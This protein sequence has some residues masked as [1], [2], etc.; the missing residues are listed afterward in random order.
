MPLDRTVQVK[1]LHHRETDNLALL[2]R[3]DSD[4]TRCARSIAEVRFSVTH[5]C[6]YVPERP[7]LLAEIFA[8][9]KGVAWVDITALKKAGQLNT[10]P[11]PPYLPELTTPEPAPVDLARVVGARPRAAAPGGTLNDLQSQAY[12]MMEQKLHL[13]GYSPNTVRTYLQAFKEFML[14]YVDEDPQNLTE[15]EIRNYVLYLIEQRKLSRST[16][17]QAI[18]AIKFFYEKL[19]LQP[20]KTYYLDR[21]MKEQ[22]LPEVLS[23]EEVMRIFE[24]VDNLKHRVMLMVLYSAGLRRSELINL[25]VGD[26]DLH[27]HMVLIRGGKGRK[28]RQTVVAQNLVPALERYV[29]EYKPGFWLFEGVKGERYS[30][31]SL[32]QVLKQAVQRAGITKRVRL[33]MLRHSFATHLLESG[34]S[35]R[36]IQIL[37]GHESPKTTEIYAHV[38]RF[39]LE[40][41]ESPLDKIVQKRQLRDAD[42]GEGDETKQ[43]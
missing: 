30:A 40:N 8:A 29:A 31:S 6:W 3:V 20:R 28:D 25:R 33:H 9:F 15:F 39:A 32:Q 19:L 41:I 18:N 34:T 4:L 38:T 1:R 36:Y 11:S 21:P 17:N 2:F 27:R 12:R 7:N 23:T 26:V 14:F 24:A 37:L 13:R 22:R 42:G 16:Q 10:A 5:K 43:K 35:T